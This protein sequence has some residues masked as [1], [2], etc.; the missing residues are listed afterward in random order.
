MSEAHPDAAL[1]DFGAVSKL[2]QSRLT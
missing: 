1:M 2:V